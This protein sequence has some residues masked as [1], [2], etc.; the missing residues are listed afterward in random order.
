MVHLKHRDVMMLRAL[1]APL[2]RLEAY[3]TTYALAAGGGCFP[4]RV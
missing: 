3:K 2:D 4:A 1:R